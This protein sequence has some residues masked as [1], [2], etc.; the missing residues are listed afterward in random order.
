MST[1]TR[2][3][4]RWPNQVE[5]RGRWEWCRTVRSSIRKLVKKLGPVRA[6]RVCYEA[7]PT[8]YVIYWQ[9]TA[10]RVRCEVVERRPTAQ[11]RRAAARQATNP[12]RTDFPTFVFHGGFHTPCVPHSVHGDFIGSSVPFYGSA[13][14][15]PSNRRVPHLFALWKIRSSVRGSFVEYTSF[16]DDDRAMTSVSPVDVNLNDSGAKRADEIRYRGC[17]LT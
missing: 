16:F 2:S 13:R 8:G 17:S 10:L 3:P 5:K 7:G 6:L 4:L 11:E 15:R 12:A 14:G 9:L 1:R